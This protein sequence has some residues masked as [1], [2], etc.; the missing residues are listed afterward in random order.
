MAKSDIE[1]SRE[2][3][4]RRESAGQ[5]RLTVRVWV[6]QE[7]KEKAREAAHKALKR[8]IAPNPE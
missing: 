1:R 2:Y 7:E 3:T 5:A 8:F 4:E 6:Y